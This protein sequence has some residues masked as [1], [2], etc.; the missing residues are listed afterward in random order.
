MTTNAVM[1][2]REKAREVVRAH[3]YAHIDIGLFTDNVDDVTMAGWD[4]VRAEIDM[5]CALLI[6][7]EKRTDTMLMRLLQDMAR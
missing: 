2:N 7:A 6:A 4:H 1:Y 5:A 3:F